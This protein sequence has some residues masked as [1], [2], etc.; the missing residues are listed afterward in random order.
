MKYDFESGKI[1][2]NM[3]S[4]DF[5]DQQEPDAREKQSDFW[6]EYSFSRQLLCLRLN[7]LIEELELLVDENEKFKIK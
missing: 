7:F 5:S 3:F 4:L 1:K 6:I 2:T